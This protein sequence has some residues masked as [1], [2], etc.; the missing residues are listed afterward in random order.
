MDMI[1]TNESAVTPNLKKKSLH[2]EHLKFII[3][4]KLAFCYHRVQNFSTLVPNS[5]DFTDGPEPW[6][7]FRNA[8]ANQM[9][10]LGES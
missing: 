9:L 4:R 6:V 3:L 5:F 2:K 1:P 7:G 10:C 8:L